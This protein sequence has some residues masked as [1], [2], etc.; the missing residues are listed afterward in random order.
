MRLQDLC[1]KQS[2][3]VFRLA[4]EKSCREYID[5]LHHAFEDGH[6]LSRAMVEK[7]FTEWMKEDVLRFVKAHPLQYPSVEGPYPVPLEW[8]SFSMLGDDST[9]YG[10]FHPTQVDDRWNIAFVIH[11]PASLY[12]V[13]F[14]KSPD[15]EKK[16]ESITRR[17]TGTF[18]HELNHYLQAVNSGVNWVGPKH[19]QYAERIGKELLSSKLSSNEIDSYAIDVSYE[20]RNL[21]KDR[22]YSREEISNML[23]SR[24]GVDELGNRISYLR[25]IHDLWVE[26][27]NPSPYLR[28]KPENIKIGKTLYQ[29]FMKKVLFHFEDRDFRIH[30]IRYRKGKTT[31]QKWISALLGGKK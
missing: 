10:M 18:I 28:S 19:Q 12:D 27:S 14:W 15:I 21:V 3:N 13:S 8:I 30:G 11:F 24:S 5:K 26:L 1:E 17:L 16:K 22:I 23:K 2:M 4:I 25:M 20:L 29:S 7:S 31:L 6:A 9:N